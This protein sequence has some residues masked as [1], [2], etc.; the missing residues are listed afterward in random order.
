LPD[1]RNRVLDAPEMVEPKK[2]LLRRLAAL[3]NLH[4]QA[5]DGIEKFGSVS[6]FQPGEAKIA[7]SMGS[8]VTTDDIGQ[9]TLFQDAH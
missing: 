9:G 6:V 8:P 5:V 4:A 2:S 7:R 1:L 3:S